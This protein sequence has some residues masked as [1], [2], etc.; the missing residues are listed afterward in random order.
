MKRETKQGEKLYIM[1]LWYRG[2]VRNLVL[3]S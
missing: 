3:N 1:Y 2:Y